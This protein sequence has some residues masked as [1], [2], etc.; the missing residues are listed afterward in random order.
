MEFIPTIVYQFCI[1]FPDYHNL[2]DQRIHYHRAILDKT[3]PA[4]FK[5]LIVK[6]LQELEK[7]GKGIGKRLTIIIDRL[8]ECNSADA[9]CKIIETIAAAACNG[10]TPFC[11]AFFSC[12]EAHIDA[13]FTCT[14]VIRVTCTSLLPISN[15]ANSD[16]KLYLCNGF[17]NI[18]QHHNIPM[19]HQ[20]PSDS[21]IQMLVKALSG[22]FIYAVT[23][24]QDV[25]QAG[26]LKRALHAVCTTT[27]NLTNS[28]PFMG[29]NAFYMVI[30]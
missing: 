19:K 5:A 4:Q 26:S 2:I 8:D 6:P 14:D 17:E 27:T 18:L 7:A 13:T 25:D 11:W 12:P 20:W 30:M 9:Q 22:L 1:R 24:L 10:I 28:P 29:L 21:D 16:I 3:M 15:D 23:A